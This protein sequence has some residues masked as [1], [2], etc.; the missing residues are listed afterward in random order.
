[1]SSRSSGSKLEREVVDL[2]NA[3][4]LVSSMAIGLAL[5]DE[6]GVVLQCNE[7]AAA[8]FGGDKSK[9][10]GKSIEDFPWHAVHE[11]G[12]ALEREEWPSS[13]TVVTGEP[14]SEVIIGVDDARRSRRWL[15]V[16]SFPVMNEAPFHRVLSSFTDV[17]NRVK[18]DQ[19]QRMLN[20]VNRI[21]MNSSSEADALEMLCDTLVTEGG[22][23]LA[24]IGFN[25][26]GNYASPMRIGFMSGATQYITGA[27]TSELKSNPGG[28]S[29]IRRALTTGEIQVVDDFRSL[30]GFDPW[31]AR[32]EEFNL[33]SVVALPF[34][35]GGQRG[36]LAI[37]DHHTYAFDERA[38]RDLEN[39]AREAEF[40]VS[41]VLAL[42]GLESALAGTIN[43]LSQMTETRDPYTAG[44]Q[45][46]VGSLSRAIAAQLDLDEELVNLIA[47]SGEVHDIGKIAV[48]AEILT[49]PGRLSD[50][51]YEMVKRH[52]TVGAGILADASLPW[53][54]AEVAL[55]H[56]ERL[57]GSGY[58]DGLAGD[59]IILP[60]RIVSVADVVEA[61]TQ[62]RPYRP[63]LG[64]EIALEEIQRGAGTIYDS[65]VVNACLTLFREGFAFEKKSLLR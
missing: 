31:T 59:E 19:A 47:L 45:I 56:H 14:C 10:L 44:H 41:H 32:A 1:M 17:T 12:R 43:A 11:N 49:R 13:Q 27:T 58:P 25:D 60:V 23:A 38:V 2:M 50:L 61:M 53:P 33:R 18:S 15:S 22:Y 34:D 28:L 39:I 57:D 52:T 62:H 63:A 20:K 46:H 24:G 4:D 42:R 26:D 64:L 48:P 5:Q 16:G 30:E 37:F 21:V 40:C 54:L 3:S 65:H 7:V 9:V 36:V 6:H 51:E 35:P 29:P 55:R 8:L